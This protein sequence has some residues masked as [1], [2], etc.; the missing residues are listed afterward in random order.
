MCDNDITD[1]FYTLMWNEETNMPYY[2]EN[3]TLKL[4]GLPITEILGI[5]WHQ[6]QLQ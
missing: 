6:Y 5:Y 1:V 2:K 4:E 3:L